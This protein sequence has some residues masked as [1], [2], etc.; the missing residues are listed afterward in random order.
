MALCCHGVDYSYDHDY[1]YNYDYYCDYVANKNNEQRTTNHEPRRRLRLQLRLLR[2]RLRLQPL[3][4][5]ECDVCLCTVL[6][7]LEALLSMWTNMWCLHGPSWLRSTARYSISK[8]YWPSWF[9]Q[10]PSMFWFFLHCILGAGVMVS[11]NDSKTFLCGGRSDSAENGFFM[12]PGRS[13]NCIKSMK[14]YGHQKKSR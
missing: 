9:R 6:L 2:L 13:Q 11:E 10:P 3:S 12:C 1:D 8:K 4:H 7:R 14:I 5:T